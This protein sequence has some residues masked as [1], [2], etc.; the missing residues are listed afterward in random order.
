MNLSLKVEELHVLWCGSE[1]GQIRNF[2]A[3]EMNLKQKYSEKLILLFL[4]CH[5]YFFKATDWLKRQ[6]EGTFLPPPPPHHNLQRLD[7]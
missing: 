6:L 7:F 2:R 3:S 4:Q 5:G 1:S